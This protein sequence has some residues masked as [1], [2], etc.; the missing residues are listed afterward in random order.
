MRIAAGSSVGTGFLIDG[1]RVLT[2]LHVVGTVLDGKVV[3]HGPIRVEGTIAEGIHLRPVVAV[4]DSVEDMSFDAA[5]DWICLQVEGLDALSRSR[6]RPVRPSDE[7]SEWRTYGF[8]S[9]AQADG[10]SAG[11]RF[12]SINSAVTLHGVQRAVLQVFAEELG[13]GDQPGGF[14]G[15]PLFVGDE[16]VGMFFSSGIRPG[17][18]TMYAL[19]VAPLLQRLFITV[20]SREATLVYAAMDLSGRSAAA[21]LVTDDPDRLAAEIGTWPSWLAT[22]AL[23]ADAESNRI[24]NAKLDELLREPQLRRELLQRRFSVASFELYVYHG[25]SPDPL[26]RET[27]LFHRLR[28]KKKPIVATVASHEDLAGNVAT[29][30]ARI[31]VMDRR[32]VSPPKLVRPPAALSVLT[33]LALGIVARRLA[34]PNDTETGIEIEFV[35]TRLR[36]VYDVTTG[37]LHRRERNPLP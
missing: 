36:L 2:A 11:G 6:V 37:V 4:L 20:G 21:A 29:A 30:V 27:L 25:P 26:I 22:S 5:F 14:S 28:K 24:R 17:S 34:S 3:P 18:G 31:A 35:R 23:R 13:A 16:I 33:D 1:S 7:T 10:K 32:I 12:R 19:P 8:P 9:E 15:A